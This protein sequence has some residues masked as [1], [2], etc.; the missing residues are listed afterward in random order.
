MTDVQL[1]VHPRGTD[2]TSAL[3]TR[4]DRMQVLDGHDPHAGQVGVVRLVRLDGGELVARVRFHDGT[5]EDYW[6]DELAPRTP[7]GP[8]PS[9]RLGEARE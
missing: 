3:P 9:A 7:K 5:T 1:Y 8:N 6:E 2:P 4:G